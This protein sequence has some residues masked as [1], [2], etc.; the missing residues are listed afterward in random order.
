[1]QERD[2]FKRDCIERM[3]ALGITLDDLRSE[4]PKKER[5]PREA[6]LKYRNPETGDE[7]SGKTPAWLE[8]L[9]DQGRAMEEFAIG[10]E[11]V[12]ET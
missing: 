4:K 3:N 10:T 2:D 5:K 9:L 1:M 12:D 6:K 7:R 8:A 11:R